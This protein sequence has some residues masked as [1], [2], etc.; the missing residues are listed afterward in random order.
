MTY[1]GRDRVVGV[2]VVFP[3]FFFL[4]KNKDG[5]R[6]GV[7]GNKPCNPDNPAQTYLSA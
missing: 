4:K 7:T 6:G 2:V 5:S 1:S 3:L